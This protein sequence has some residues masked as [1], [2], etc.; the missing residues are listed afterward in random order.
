[1]K[2]LL[3]TYTNYSIITFIFNLS[4]FKNLY[5][6]NVDVPITESLKK[7]IEHLVTVFDFM[8]F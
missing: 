5:I 3:I 2:R 7:I 6:Y 8:S 1:M 4:K